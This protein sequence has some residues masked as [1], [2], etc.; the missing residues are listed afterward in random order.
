MNAPK[1]NQYCVYIM[2]NKYNN[3]LYTGVTSDLQRR[4]TEH[5]AGKSGSFTKKYRLYK[6][7]Y[8]EPGDS[9]EAAILREKD[10]KAGTRKKKIGLVNSINPGWEDLFDFFWLR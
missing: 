8:Y 2:T 10:I 9:I 5:R 1:E 6:L 7:V 4:V 3:V